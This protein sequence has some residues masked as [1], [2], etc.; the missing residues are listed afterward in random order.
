MKKIR[1]LLGLLL[2]TLVGAFI[3]ENNAS[4][5]AFNNNQFAFDFYREITHEKEGN[6]FFSPNSISTALA[7]TYAG[8]DHQ[9]ADEMESVLHFEKNTPAFHMAY[10]DYLQGLEAQAEGN[11]ELSIANQ[12]WGEKTYTFNSDYLNLIQKAYN[13]PLEQVDFKFHAE[14]QRER[15]NN[16]V[17]QKTN[18]KIKDIIPEGSINSLTRL[19]LANAIYFKGDWHLKFDEKDTKNKKFKNFNGSTSK[20]PF[21]NKTTTVNYAENEVF[22]MIQLPYKGE[23]HSMV[24]ALPQE[25][26]TITDVE[27][28]INADY[29]TQITQTYGSEV[30]IAL[31][32][33]KLEHAISLG[34]ILQ[35]MG[36]EQA[37][38]P[39]AD[40]GKMTPTKDL[41]ISE[42]LHKAFI[43][44][45]EKG[46][47]AAAATVVIMAVTTSAISTP[48][49]VRTFIADQPFVFYIIDHNTHSILFMGRIMQL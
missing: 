30:I 18:D 41:Y 39:T 2:L 44:V 49:I 34:P 7:M 31:P 29:L 6:V 28:H 45:D 12:L 22:K 16:W 26:K 42:A 23:K 47:E 20:V 9:T 10:G 35:K 38:K 40:F 11:I 3:S 37:F 27:T 14:D 5:I 32:K 19:V 36:M 4:K 43:E 1:I 24:L 46:T 25:G 21:M 8:A 15:I 13:A 33:F 17:E 48:P